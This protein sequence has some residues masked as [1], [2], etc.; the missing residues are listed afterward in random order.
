MDLDR[1]TVKAPLHHWQEILEEWVFVNK[2]IAR[3]TKGKFA[4]YLYKE[5]TNLGVLA[6]AGVKSGW[7]ALEECRTEKSGKEDETLS[8]QG[9]ADLLLW[10]DNRH[11]QVEAKFMRR[12]LTAPTLKRIETVHGKAKNDA[13]R[14]TSNESKKENFIALTFIVPWVKNG[15]ITDKTPSHI[16]VFLDDLYRELKPTIFASVFPGE[17]GAPLVGA[18]HRT[19]LGII[20][21]GE[22]MKSL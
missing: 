21:I 18:E 11:D 5:R 9:R 20:L 12:S 1:I 16:N 8:Y 19:G 4:P 7:A 10:R 15:E 17:V 3:I 2:K 14:S 13:V 22:V 6:S